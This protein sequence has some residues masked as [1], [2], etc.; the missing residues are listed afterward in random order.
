MLFVQFWFTFYLFKFL[1]LPSSFFL[2]IVR[3]CKTQTTFQIKMDNF[4]LFKV[5]LSLFL[6][7]V[8]STL[9]NCSTASHLTGAGRR[10]RA[11]RRRKLRHVLS[12][13]SPT[14][15]HVSFAEA[16]APPTGLLDICSFNFLPRQR[17]AEKVKS[18]SSSDLPKYF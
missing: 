13:K 14:L 18:D 17:R 8:C 9:A 7:C 11:A 16:A 1:H 3:L 6:F 4:I 12:L 2:S 10:K 15:S 5:F